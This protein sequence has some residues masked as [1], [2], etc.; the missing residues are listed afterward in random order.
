MF[1]PYAAML[2]IV[3]LAAALLFMVIRHKRHK[4]P[5]PLILREASANV[6]EGN[7]FFIKYIVLNERLSMLFIIFS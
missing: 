4:H 7:D 3:V 5:V 6:R 2:V 1:I